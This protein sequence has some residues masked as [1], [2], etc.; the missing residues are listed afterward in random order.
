[1]IQATLS[2]DKQEKGERPALALSTAAFQIRS[3]QGSD[4]TAA[5]GRGQPRAARRVRGQEALHLWTQP[6]RLVTTPDPLPQTATCSL[7]RSDSL[8]DWVL[9][10]IRH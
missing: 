5:G 9:F 8:R 3:E 1:M 6:L 4:L 7:C 10:D 2:R